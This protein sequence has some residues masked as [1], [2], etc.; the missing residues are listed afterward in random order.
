MNR[1]AVMRGGAVTTTANEQFALRLMASVA[2]HMTLVMPI[3][4]VDGLGGAHVIE[5]R[6]SGPAQSVD[7]E[8]GFFD[9][10]RRVHPHLIR[11]GLLEPCHFHE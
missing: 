9:R 5:R 3:G 8:L 11:L 2:R 7:E 10:R 4:N 1:V 6:V